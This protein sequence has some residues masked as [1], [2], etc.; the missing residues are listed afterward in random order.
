MNNLGRHSA[1]MCLFPRCMETFQTPC[2]FKWTL[3]IVLHVFELLGF[4]GNQFNS[5]VKQTNT[6]QNSIINIT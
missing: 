6:D 3:F 4:G 2:R 5:P 1:K